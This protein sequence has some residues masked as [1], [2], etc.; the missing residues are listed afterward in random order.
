MELLPYLENLKC[1][2]NKGLAVLV[3]PDANTDL[4]KLVTVAVAHEV[5]TFFVGGS[6]L[7]KDSLHDTL[8][9]LTSKSN[10]PCYIFPGSSNQVSDQADGIL[11][12]SLISG[13]NPDYLIGQQVMAAPLIKEAQIDVIPTGYI[14][15]DGGIQTS[16]SYM[17]NTTPIPSDKAAIA[18]ATALAGQYLGLKLIYMDTGSGAQNCVSPDMIKAVKK[19]TSVPL[20]VGG[21]IRD[22]QSA[23]RALEAGADMIVVGNQLEVEPDFVKE[24]MGLIQSMNKVNV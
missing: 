2:N 23:Q 21:G 20:V 8:I 7:T 1:N 14:L 9:T 5:D 11:F 13:R 18:S 6:L 24:L 17:S 22:L 16:V 4:H 12:L 3:D 15:I 19:T 10:I